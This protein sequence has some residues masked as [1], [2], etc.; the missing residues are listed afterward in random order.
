MTASSWAMIHL[1]RTGMFRRLKGLQ[2]PYLEKEGTMEL[3][4]KRFTE[5]SFVGR[6]VSNFA[7]NLFKAGTGSG[8]G[9]FLSQEVCF[10]FFFFFF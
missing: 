10:F 7:I 1:L 8:S 5:L 4:A 6:D 3:I 2:S 9:D